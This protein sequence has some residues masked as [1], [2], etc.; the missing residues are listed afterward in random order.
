MAFKLFKKEYVNYLLTAYF[1]LI[2]VYSLAVAISPFL[3]T[4][5]YRNKKPKYLIDWKFKI[6]FV[7]DPV[8][9]QLNFADIISLILASIFGSWYIQ[10][11][12]WCGNNI[13]GIAF[14]IQ[15]DLTIHLITAS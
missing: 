5:I 2:G 11:K 9:I 13:F 14:S 6:P 1:F 15:V 4:L 7:N 8:E 3:E 10:T 12:H